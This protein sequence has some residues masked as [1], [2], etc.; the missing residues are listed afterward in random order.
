M[1]H[2]VNLPSLVCRNTGMNRSQLSRIYASPCFPLEMH[3]NCT[4]LIENVILIKE[5][6]I[7]GLEKQKNKEKLIEKVATDL[8]TK[9]INYIRKNSNVMT[10]QSVSSAIGLL[11]TIQNDVS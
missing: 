7:K 11:K 5:R 10:N 8:I 1:Q 3:L 2:Y 4:P 9:L 6:Q